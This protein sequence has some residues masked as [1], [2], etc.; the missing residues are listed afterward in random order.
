M[1]T[2]G[3]SRGVRAPRYAYFCLCQSLVEW[4]WW[5]WSVCD[6]GRCR[7]GFETQTC[8]VHWGD[9]E[10]ETSTHAS[11]LCILYERFLSPKRTEQ[12]NICESIWWKEG[13]WDPDFPLMMFFTWERG[14]CGSIIKTSFSTSEPSSRFPFFFLFSE[15]NNFF[16]WRIVFSCH[17]WVSKSCPTFLWPHRL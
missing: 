2:L 14:P 3:H 12:V 13:F 17:C 9:L 5:W 10:R 4:Q 16:K 1:E 7:P 8:S 11:Q 6:L 15:G